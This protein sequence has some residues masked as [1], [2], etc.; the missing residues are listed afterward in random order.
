MSDTDAGMPPTTVEQIANA[1]LYEGYLLYPYRP[2]SVKN[3]QR[4]TFGGVYPRAYSE[5]QAGSDAWSVGFSCLVLDDGGA[6][7]DVCARF[8]HLLD[9]RTHDAPSQSWQEAVEREVRADDLTLGLL[10]QRPRRVPFGFPAGRDD[11]AR[12]VR[13]R[14]AILGAVEIGA[15]R[16]VVPGVRGL[17]RLTVSL[18]NLTP[19]EPPNV[20]D[21]GRRDAALMHALVSAH[22]ILRVRGGCFVSQQDPPPELSEAS[23]ACQNAGLW[24]VLAGEPGQHDTLLVSPI[25]LYDYP[26]IAPESPGDLFDGT[27]IDEILTLRI[28]TLTDAEKAELRQSDE[29]AR[30]LLDRTESLDANALIGLHGTM[31]QP[32]LPLSRAWGRAGGGE[33]Q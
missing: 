11:D 33:G 22:A 32:R 20:T 27:E 31:R 30:A 10:A 9:R 26:E 18:L 7:V 13:E 8:L 19:F 5:A 4:W 1:V 2:S 24:P 29:R 12:M 21:P 23:A 14:H 28:L 16:I 17:Y 3:R 25:I 6:T 15:E